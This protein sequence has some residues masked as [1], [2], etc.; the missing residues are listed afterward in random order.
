MDLIVDHLLERGAYVDVL[1]GLALTALSR[2]AI[3]GKDLVVTCLLARG[4]DP[5]LRGFCGQTA[6]YVGS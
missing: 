3:P 1:D 4:A 2:A 6:L 5:N